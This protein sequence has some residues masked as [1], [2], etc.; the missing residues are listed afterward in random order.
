MAELKGKVAV[1]TGG[2]QGIGLA[3]AARFLRADA[4]VVV[5]DLNPPSSSGFAFC[6]ADVSCEKEAEN[7]FH[8]AEDQ[9]G[10]VDILVNNAG[11]VLEKSIL[12]TSADEWDKM[13]AVNLRGVFLCAKFA[14]KKMQKRG[15]GAIVN[16]GSLEGLGANP[17]HSAY[18]ASKGAVHSLTRNIALEFGTLGIRCNAVAPGWIQTPLNDSLIANY[19]NPE[20][21][22]DAI[23]RLHPVGRMGLPEDIAECALWLAGD[24]SSFASGQIFV[25]D[26]GRTA[27]LPLPPME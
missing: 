25:M 4:K 1:V 26:G 14:A 18:A 5:G 2:S 10:G 27:K 15:G 8:F 7:L 3:I 20:S 24:S 6:R 21:A 16:I 11:I 22:L 17:L 19:P 9:F 12:E 23:K 13:M